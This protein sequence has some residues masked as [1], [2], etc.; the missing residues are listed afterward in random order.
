MADII[1]LVIIS[2]LLIATIT[3]FTY[4]HIKDKKESKYFE[5]Y[6]APPYLR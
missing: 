1:V 6:P 3:F 5:D 2:L 4:L